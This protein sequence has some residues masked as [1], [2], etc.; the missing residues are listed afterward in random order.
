MNWYIEALRKYAVFYGRSRRKEFWFF[1]LF[2]LLFSLALTMAD[3]A[4]GT[5][6]KEAG[7]GVLS[8]IYTAAVFLPGLAVAVRRL[9][10]IGRSG[11]W[12]L[13]GLIPVVG[14]IVL[15]FLFMLDSQPGDNRFG[16]NPKANELAAAP[17]SGA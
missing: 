11:W 15:L 5:L 12:V 13:I 7:I 16:Q 17:G 1:F 9:H 14:T 8:G 6:N 10:D 2:N 3:D 4:L